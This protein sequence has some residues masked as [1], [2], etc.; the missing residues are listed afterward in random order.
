M[1]QTTED[2]MR[3]G[4]TKG[5]TYYEENNFD[6]FNITKFEWRVQITCKNINDT[7]LYKIKDKSTKSVTFVPN[8]NMPSSV[9]SVGVLAS[10]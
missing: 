7:Y 9:F 4:M 3:E 1:I 2:C 8:K 10:P 6:D 5:V